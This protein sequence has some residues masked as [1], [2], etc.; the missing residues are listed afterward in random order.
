MK[1]LRPSNKIEEFAQ[2]LRE[3]NITVFIR[4]NAGED[5]KAACGQL[6]ILNQ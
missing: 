2:K 6:A 1:I 4:S 5:I 3:N